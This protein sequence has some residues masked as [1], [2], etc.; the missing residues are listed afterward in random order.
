MV[1]LKAISD[2]EK[3][4]ITQALNYLEASR[5]EVGLLINFGSTSLQFH[6]MHL[7]GKSI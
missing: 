5:I 2:L 6:R 7:K 4:D 3:R 1:E